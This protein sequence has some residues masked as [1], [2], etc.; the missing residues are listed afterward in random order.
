MKRHAMIHYP[1]L[2]EDLVGEPEILLAKGAS[3]S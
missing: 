1:T 3:A 2:F